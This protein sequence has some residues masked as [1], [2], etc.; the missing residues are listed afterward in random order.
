MNAKIFQNLEPPQNYMHKM[1]DKRQVPPDSPQI[2][3][4]TIQNL[5]EFTTLKTM[6]PE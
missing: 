6:W 2:L 3:G 5:L 4:A 1:G